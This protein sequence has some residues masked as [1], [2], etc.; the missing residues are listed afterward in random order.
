MKRW[1]LK[2]VYVLHKPN[3]CISQKAAR[4]YERGKTIALPSRPG[5]DVT[6]L[7]NQKKTREGG[8]AV[9]RGN[10]SSTCDERN[11]VYINIGIE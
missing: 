2:K 11:L 6:V 1:Y 3:R 9:V 7:I 10:L 5:Q 8:L 4:K